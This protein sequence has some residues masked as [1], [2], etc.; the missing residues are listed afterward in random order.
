M[1]EARF[2]FSLLTFLRLQI[3]NDYKHRVLGL[4]TIGDLCLRGGQSSWRIVWNNEFT[5]TILSYL[6]KRLP[7]SLSPRLFC[8]LVH[9]LNII[10]D[11]NNASAAV[12]FKVLF[13]NVTRFVVEKSVRV[14]TP[15][16]A[17]HVHFE[18][19]LD[20]VLALLICSDN[21]RDSQDPSFVWFSPKSVRRNISVAFEW[22][23]RR[24]DIFLRI[25]T[26]RSQKTTPYEILIHL[27]H[28]IC[29]CETAG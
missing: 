24:I 28:L 5:V 7:L 9:K 23:L 29:L 15:R 1:F 13:A 4:R 27:M 16:D 8:S 20:F 17:P 14:S 10:I 25:V 2:G 11:A 12:R 18:F 21:L 6:Q 26:G 19:R 3:S 22:S